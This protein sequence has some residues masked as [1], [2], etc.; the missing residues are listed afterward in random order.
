MEANTT[1]SQPSPPHR[2]RR[3]WVPVVIAV[4]LLLL[5]V[6]GLCSW[7]VFGNG[8][9]TLLTIQ[10]RQLV[11]NPAPDFTLATTSGSE[12]TLSELEGQ[13]VV[14]NFWATWCPDCRKEIPTLVAAADTYEGRAVLLGVSA[15]TRGTVAD[16]ADANGVNYPLL[17]DK[18]RAANTSYQIVGLPTTYLIDAQGVVRKVHIGE[19]DA[20]TLDKWLAELEEG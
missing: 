20:A 3:W 16:F 15:E 5:G 9:G 12:L 10:S 1:D 13:P 2:K 17:L 14:L 4:P 11:G 18:N 6:C 7:I 19:I 8:L